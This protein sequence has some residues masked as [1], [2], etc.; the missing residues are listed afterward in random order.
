MKPGVFLCLALLLS[1]VSSE[2][3][4]LYSVSSSPTQIINPQGSIRGGTAIFISGV[5]FDTSAANNQVFIGPYPCIVP[6]KGASPTVL[7]CVTSDTKQNNDIYNLPI[8][9][10]VN[11]QQQSLTNEQGCFSY[12]NIKTP[13]ITELFPASSHAN[14]L[15]NFYG[16]H[17]ITNL[18]DG[19]RDMGDVISMKIGDTLCG[20]FDIV[21]SSI[22]ANSG[23]TISCRQSTVQRGGKY[24]V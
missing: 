4:Q 24:F 16:T 20:R 22:A 17:R 13:L 11:G 12:V 5:G 21:Q 9:V 8:I 23:D 18:G 7:S 1:C 2:A 19:N 15:V 3:L 10:T 6:A 14:T